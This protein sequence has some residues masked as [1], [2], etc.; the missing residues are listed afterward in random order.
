MGAGKLGGGGREKKELVA[1]NILKFSSH[2][3]LV[4]CM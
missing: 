3:K 4:S 1:M 2:L